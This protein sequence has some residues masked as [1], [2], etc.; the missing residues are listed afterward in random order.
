MKLTTTGDV[1][2]ASAAVSHVLTRNDIHASDDD[3][4]RIAYFLHHA[5]DD[6]F[7]Q[8]ELD[9]CER[10][11]CAHRDEII[12]TLKR[13][14]ELYRGFDPGMVKFHPVTGDALTPERNAK[15]IETMLAAEKS[16]CRPSPKK[17]RN[18][19]TS[20]KNAEAETIFGL[21]LQ[22]KGIDQWR[23]CGLIAEMFL[24]LGIDDKPHKRVQAALYDKLSRL[25]LR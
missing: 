12:Q 2:T 14:A 4:R 25:I 18:R 3:I 6:R 16:L 20:A 9:D 10:K 21:L 24:R 22:H 8:D 23:A 19:P 15:E 17:P 5:K 1:D 11:E 7:W 13:L